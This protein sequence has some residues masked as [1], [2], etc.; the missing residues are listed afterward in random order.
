MEASRVIFVRLRSVIESMAIKFDF[1]QLQ[2]WELDVSMNVAPVQLMVQWLHI[3]LDEIEVK[4][5]KLINNKLTFFFLHFCIYFIFFFFHFERFMG[6]NRGSA[7]LMGTQPYS[8][9]V[10]N[11]CSQTEKYKSYFAARLID[12]SMIGTSIFSLAEKKALRLD[13]SPVEWSKEKWLVKFIIHIYGMNSTL[14]LSQF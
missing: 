13:S 10:W 9:L 12:G 1:R 2:E 6:D 8:Y 11:N 5:Q 7:A 14:G 4:A 3:C